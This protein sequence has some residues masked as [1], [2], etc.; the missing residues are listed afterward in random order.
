MNTYFPGG[1]P[2]SVM[3][4]TWNTGE[5]SQLYEQNFTPKA[6]ETARPKERMLD[7]ISDIILPTFIEYVSDVIIVCTQEM[8]PVKKRF[9]NETTMK[10]II[11]NRN[12]LELIG[13]YFCKKLSVQLMFSFIRFI[14]ELYLC[15]FF[16]VV[17]LFGFA[18]VCYSS[19]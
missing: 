14:L 2:L 7:D 10:T 13:K 9:V 15:A 3:L 12:H 11:F 8:S 17:I 18:R 19:F 1:R 16:Y 4:V 6:R 5:A